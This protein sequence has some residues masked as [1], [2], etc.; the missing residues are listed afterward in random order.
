MRTQRWAASVDHAVFMAMVAILAFTGFRLEAQ[1]AVIVKLV[2]VKKPGA[3]DGKAM[4]TVKAPVKVN[5]KIIIREKTGHIATHALQAWTIMNGQGALLLLSPEKKGGQ[6]QLR[7]Y[8]LDEGK[9]RP[10]GDVPFAQA[11]MVESPAT[12]APWAFAL[13]GIDPSTGQPVIFAG[14]VQAIHAQLPNASNPYF[15]ADALC[16][17]STGRQSA[18]EPRTL[19]IP[20]LMGEEALG[21]IY[22]PRNSESQAAYLQFLP[23][24]DS[25]TTTAAGEVNRGRWITDGSQFRITTAKGPVAVW[26][27]ADLRT[28]AGIPAGSHLNVRLLHPLS[29]RTAKKGT[30]VQ[31]VLI[32]PGV[33]EDAILIPQGSEFDGA[34]VQAQSVGWGIRH[35]TAALT[36]HFDSVKL[37]DG[38]TLSIDA[39]VFRVENARENVTAAGKIQGIRSTGTIG[40]SAENQIASLAQIDPIAY[41]YTSLAG[42]A[43]LGFAEPEILYN[44]GTELDIQINKPVITAQKYP[45]RVP[46]MDLSGE[47]AVQFS[48]VVR[49][50][51]FLTRT[52][53]THQP[54]DITN[55][56]FIGK[57]EALRR[58]F[59]AAGW[60]TADTLTAAATFET[61]KTLAGNQTYTE[62]PMSMLM[63]GDERPIFA[64]EKSNNTFS[65]RHH[66]R[67]FATGESFDGEQVL[68]ASST[69]DI[70]IAF[71][72]KQKTFIHVIDQYLDNERSKVTND[73]EFTGCVDS[74]DMVSRP[75]VPRD[76][77]NS[78]G[79]RLITDGDA[80]VL[81]LNDCAS[82]YATPTTA[83]GRPPLTERSERDT[84]LTIK[85]T[86]Y[87][88]N[89][90]Y[91]G[92]SGG[93]K[94]HQYL[95]TQGELG[96]Q[97]GAWRRSDASGT[98]YRVV[99]FS[100]P[101][102][103]RRNWDGEASLAPAELDAEAR[104]RVDAH[105]WDP[106]H[107]EIGLNLGYSNYRNHEL[108]S[109]FVFLTSSNC[110]P[111]KC[112]EP[113]YAI[114]LA[115]NVYD[116]W[117][118]STSLTLNSWNWISNEFSYAR[119]QTKFFLLG[120]SGE[121]QPQPLPPL[122]AQTVGWTTRRFAYNTVFNL[123][124]RKSRWRPYITAGPALQLL[125]LA[126]APLK[127][128][129]GYFR[130]GLSNIGLLK[131]AIDFGATPPLN[132]GGTYQ[133][134]LQY[135]AGFKFRL[136]PRLM[137]RADYG[138]TWSA[139]PN[140]VKRSYEG[141]IPTGLDSSYSTFVGYFGAP[142]S[143][144][145]QHS[146][147]GFSF[148]F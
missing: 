55:L 108:E 116:G 38:R 62:A 73:L 59:Q 56:I 113:M 11:T 46:H 132:G 87:R 139:N 146:T 126:N 77:Y 140:V 37:P 44:A 4:A 29:S 76:A 15:S 48:T 80:A 49:D 68:T 12:G 148:T 1:S 122:G 95:V 50:L 25:L 6:D 133:F 124:P 9:G 121:I 89:L 28:I 111:I 92:I 14:D 123:R 39:R 81:R 96:K 105:K 66:V 78:T 106:P 117:A 70:G 83:A 127:Q 137:M 138:E 134:G 16:F 47:Q 20:A 112:T 41:I 128:P 125:A 45:P 35:E 129:S 107:Y 17:Q 91:T 90:I 114:G 144:I 54:S 94:V 64:M 79:D 42:P 103:Q 131:A 13:S 69:Q 58:A 98:E 19:E 21:R 7:Y 61:V 82:P 115:D 5:G 74:I 85:D 10:L 84:V 53:N 119:E 36:L 120:F 24:G 51:P 136:T 26:R 18:G 145:Q 102:L 30:P 33:F 40:H 43:L 27:L 52:E 93:I 57:P 65:S 88:G 23:D 101:L 2:I 97:T 100:Q 22:A 135:G 86:L 104:A 34:L 118:A 130:L 143:Y 75:W 142:A 147:V 8:Q 60:K 63:L 109:V 72:Y 71:S 31:A 67:V 99:A 32:S 3:L 110:T 141:Y